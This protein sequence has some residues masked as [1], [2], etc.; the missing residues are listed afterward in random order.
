MRHSQEEII[1]ALKVIQDTCNDMPTVRACEHCPLSKN[2]DCV[3][4]NSAPEDWDIKTTPP[5]VWKAF[6]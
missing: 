4:Q 2:G 1:N 5:V 6:G 3:L